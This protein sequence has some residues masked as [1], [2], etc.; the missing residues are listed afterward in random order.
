MGDNWFKEDSKG[1]QVIVVC[2]TRRTDI[3]LYLM[4]L[5]K[6]TLSRGPH[7]ISSTTALFLMFFS[8]FKDGR[9][10]IE[11]M[12]FFSSPEQCLV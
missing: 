11:E 8:L 2:R 4:S 10:V 5:S 3:I 12:L 6:G 7:F 1:R 9:F